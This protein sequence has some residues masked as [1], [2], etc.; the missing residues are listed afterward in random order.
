MAA[1]VLALALIGAF[2]VTILEIW[3]PPDWPDDYPFDDDFS[4][5][6][7]DQERWGASLGGILALSVGFLCDLIP[8]AWIAWK[9]IAGRKSLLMLAG[10]AAHTVIGGVLL[11]VVRSAD[12]R[13]AIGAAMW[14]IPLE[15][16]WL[17]FYLSVLASRY[18]RDLLPGRSYGSA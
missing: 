18:L 10:L 12:E 14:V 4:T 11:A 5:Y 16:C 3:P 15:V 9:G 13:T 8:L 17:A 7:A 1:G 2:L 6:D